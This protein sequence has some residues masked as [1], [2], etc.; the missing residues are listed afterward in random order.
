[1]VGYLLCQLGLFGTIGHAAEL[2]LF[3]A[4]APPLAALPENWLCFAEALGA[5]DSS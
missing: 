4:S 2:G 3:G 5:P 1:M